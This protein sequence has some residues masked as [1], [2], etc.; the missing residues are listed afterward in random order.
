MNTFQTIVIGIFVTLAII[1]VGV[2][3]LYGGALGGSSVGAVVVWG[4]EDSGTLSSVLDQLRA[5]D[6][7][8]QDVQYV[9]KSAATYEN[10]LVSAMAAGSGP[11]LFFVTQAQVSKFADKIIPV[12]YG[13]VSQSSF[14]NSF[15]DEGQLFLTSSGALAL[16]LL[17]DPL[18]MY[19]NK[20]ALSSAGVP[21]A[22]KFWNDFLTIAP[23]VTQ[24]DAS[25]QVKLSAVALGHWSN[26]SHAKEILATLF[27]QAGDKITAR[28]SGGVLSSVLGARQGDAA[29]GPAESALQF[30]TEFANPSK[31]TYSW[32]KS[33]PNSIDAFAGGSVAVYFGLASEYQTLLNRNPNLRIGVAVVPQLTGSLAHA[34]FGQMTGVAISRAAQN[35][36]G[37]LTIAERITSQAGV[38]AIARVFP[39]PPVRRDVVLD[40]SGSA[41]ASVFVQSSLIARGWLDPEPSATDPMFQRMI[42]S[43]ISGKSDPA[44]AVG[45][46]AA[47]LSQLLQGSTYK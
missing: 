2:F 12:P 45:E 3:A 26:I 38:T 46:A 14:V 20:D 47:S 35:A 37:A 44:A 23:K 27:L 9:Q 40:T 32:N 31:T 8:F 42:E 11:D 10:D 36:Q 29:A 43:V 28:T 7:S 15:I 16:P 22:P 30:Y 1:G 39:L 24:L 5:Q 17:V 41:A 13:S 21:A 19:Y 4:T 33:L 34:T 6:K 18:V 25:R